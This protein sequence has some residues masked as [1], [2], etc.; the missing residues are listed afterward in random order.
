MVH[1]VMARDIFQLLHHVRPEDFEAAAAVFT[2]ITGGDGL[3]DPLQ[4]LWERFAL[5]RCA[6][7]LD[8][9]FRGLILISR[10]SGLFDL[11]L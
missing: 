3:L 9:S 11:H 10:L 4:P 2:R 7:R 5:A 6:G 1:D 8:L